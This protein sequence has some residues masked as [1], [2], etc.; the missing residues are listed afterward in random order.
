VDDNDA[1]IQ[2][3]QISGSCFGITDLINLSADDPQI[4]TDI[5]R[6]NNQSVN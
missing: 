4:F 3:M 6:I 1:N 5:S 2:I